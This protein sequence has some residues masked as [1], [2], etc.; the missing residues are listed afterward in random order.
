LIQPPSRALWEG[1]SISFRVVAAASASPQFYQWFKDGI[2][3]PEW[4]NTVIFL[5]PVSLA[6]AGIYTVT[7]S[8]AVGTVTSEPATLTVWELP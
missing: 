4:T 6:D 1:T 8:N 7:V 2:P 3:R 5:P